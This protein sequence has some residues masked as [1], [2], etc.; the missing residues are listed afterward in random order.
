MKAISNTGTA[1]KYAS[2]TLRNNKQ[3]VKAAVEETNWALKFA[4]EEIKN[5]SEIKNLKQK[6]ERNDGLPF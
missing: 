5:D 6:N 1:L 2:E 3:I 4:S